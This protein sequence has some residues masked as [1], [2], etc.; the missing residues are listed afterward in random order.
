MS[1]LSGGQ[2]FVELQKIDDQVKGILSS[3][4]ITEECANEVVDAGCLG[5][6]P[7]PFTIDKLKSMLR[8][9]MT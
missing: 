6:L 1:G 9:V 5:F 8:E 4:Y 3:G 2:T 7:K